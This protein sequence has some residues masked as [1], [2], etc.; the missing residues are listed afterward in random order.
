MEV[1][2]GNPIYLITRAG[3]K[4]THR[5]KRINKKWLKRYGCHPFKHNQVY[6]LENGA[7]WMSWQTWQKIKPL[8]LTKGVVLA[9]DEKNQR[10]F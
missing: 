10:V 6:V 4:R 1:Y 5:K 2:Q 8:L 7:I 9:A 3:Q